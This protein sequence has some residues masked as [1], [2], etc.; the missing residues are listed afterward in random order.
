MDPIWSNWFDYD[1][2]CWAFGHWAVLRKFVKPLQVSEWTQWS[3]CSFT[4]GPGRLKS[5]M[6]F[7][8]ELVEWELLGRVGCCEFPINQYKY[9]CV[10]AWWDF[11][12]ETLVWGWFLGWFRLFFLFFG[13][14]PKDNR[15][16]SDRSWRTG[17]TLS[18]SCMFLAS[19]KFCIAWQCLWSHGN[20]CWSMKCSIMSALLVILQGIEHAGIRRP[21]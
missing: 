9:W 8:W 7:V 6:F 11:S 18:A 13:K 21:C 4:C 3:S 12:R 14:L 2:R 5:D 15:N 16:V 1:R 10:S 17:D 20:T 19:A